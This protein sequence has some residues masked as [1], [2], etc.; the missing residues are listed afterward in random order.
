MAL[1]EAT[2]KWPYRRRTSDGICPS[3]AHTAANPASGHERG[4][5]FDLS[6]DPANGCDAH[7]LADRVMRARDE[8]VLYV[9][10]NRR[11]WSRARYSEGW[12]RYTGTNPHTSH[13]HFELD[14]RH[15]NSTWPWWP[16]VTTPIPPAPAGAPAFRIIDQIEVDVVTNYAEVGITTDSNGNGWTLVPYP[17]SRILGHT[18]PGLRPDADQR[19]ETSEVGFADEGNGCIVSILGW[20]PNSPAVVGLHVI[21]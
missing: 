4:E 13:A 21:N 9:I 6:H 2:Q 20:A 19:Y 15:R 5:A 11:I 16:P 7:A 8:R 3:A 12:R 1:A 10:S 14:P 18:P 17:R